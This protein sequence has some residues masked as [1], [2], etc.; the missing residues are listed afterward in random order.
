MPGR[1]LSPCRHPS[2]GP[3][4]PD[5]RARQRE[6]EWCPAAGQTHQRG[7]RPARAWDCQ[8]QSLG[9]DHARRHRDPRAGRLR[10][11]HRHAGAAAG[12][13]ARPDPD[14]GDRLVR[15]RPGDHQRRVRVGPPGPGPARHRA[16]IAGPGRRGRAGHRIRPRRPGRRHRAPARPRSLPGLRGRGLGHVHQR[17]V[18]RAGHQGPARLRLRALPHPPRLPGRGGPRPR[19]SRRPARTGHRRGQG[20]GPHRED[21]PQVHLGPRPGPDHRRRAH[22]AARRP[23][24]G[25]ARLRHLRARPGHRGPQ[26]GDGPP[27]GPPTSTAAT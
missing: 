5:A 2:P 27:A 22:R 20:L 13:R 14:P 26:T 11:A 15:H 8:P 9:W 25:S 4:S 10:R 12:G 1:S 7:C 6:P 19:H 17:P 16:R 18:H 24:V 23:A 3:G 21:R